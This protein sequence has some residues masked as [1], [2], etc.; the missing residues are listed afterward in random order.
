[1]LNIP[2]ELFPFLKAKVKDIIND[3]TRCF[4]NAFTKSF[5]DII[6]YVH[7]VQIPLFPSEDSLIW[8]SSPNGS[9]SFKETYDHIRGSYHYAQN[10]KWGKFIWNSCIPPSKS[11]LL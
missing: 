6:Q 9:L 11:F 10:M 3:N 4:P 1:M 7:E 8:Q 5:P 2:N